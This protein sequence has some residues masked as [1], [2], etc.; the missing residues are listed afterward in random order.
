[1]EDRTLTVIHCRQC[2]QDVMVPPGSFMHEREV[3]YSC[4]AD[5]TGGLDAL[6]RQCGCLQDDHFE[7]DWFDPRT[8]AA[9]EQGI[10]NTC[11]ECGECYF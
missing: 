8:E 1:M 5:I 3:C 11:G 9:L 7:P 10:L 2:G 4:I 6:C